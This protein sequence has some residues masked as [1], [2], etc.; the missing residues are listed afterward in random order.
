[1]DREGRGEAVAILRGVGK[2]LPPAVTGV[3]GVRSEERAR[4]RGVEVV[5]RLRGADR[6]PGELD[7]RPVRVEARAR[8]RGVV[9][10]HTDLQVAAQGAVLCLLPPLE[11]RIASR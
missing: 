3:A 2:H 8:D 6:E 11:P 5:E 7:E 9:V 4:R 10:V 1:G